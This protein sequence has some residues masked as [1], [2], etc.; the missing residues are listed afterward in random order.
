MT[1]DDFNTLCTAVYGVTRP[2]NKKGCKYME[3]LNNTI[4]YLDLIGIYR[5]LYST[6]AGYT[7][8]VLSPMQTMFWAIK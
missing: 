7:F 6:K 1:I 2:E 3:E 4:S 5:A 8:F